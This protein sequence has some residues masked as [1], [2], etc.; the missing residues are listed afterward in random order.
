MLVAHVRDQIARDLT[1]AT[2]GTCARALRTS[3]RTLQRR[4]RAAGTSYGEQLRRARVDAAWQ[5]VRF[6]DLKI[7]AA[8]RTPI[9]LYVAASLF[10]NTRLKANR[11]LRDV[12]VAKG[13]P[14]TYR[15]F[16]GGHDFWM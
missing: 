3:R 6:S 11:R 8:P 14:V 7:A 2:M 1:G 13:Y 12:L 16:H 10:K 5:L 4:L 15:E 9:K